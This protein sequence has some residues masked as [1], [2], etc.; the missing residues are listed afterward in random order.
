MP[1]SLRPHGLQHNRLW[2]PSLSPGVCSD[3][4]LLSWWCYLTILSSAALSP[5]AFNLSQNQGLFQWVSSS[6]KL[7]KYWSFSFS[8]SPSNEYLGLIS[9]RIDWFDL[10]AAQG[11]LKSLLQHW[12]LKASVLCCSSFFVVQLSNPYTTTGKTIA[13]TIRAFVSKVMV[14]IFKICERPL[15]AGTGIKQKRW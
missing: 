5:F 13:L 2:C 8:I 6:Y 7:A 12:N 11:T 4:R 14:F 1:D 9:F 3:S 10:L 15:H